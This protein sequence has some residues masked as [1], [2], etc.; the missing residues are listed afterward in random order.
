M[1]L[2]DGILGGV[3]ATALEVVFV[4]GPLF[5]F[6]A[7]LHLLERFTSRRLSERFGWWSLL[8][9]GWIGTPI[10]EL[11]H[12]AACLLFRHEI[13]EIALFRPDKRTGCL[14]FVNHTYNR[15]NPWH[16]AGN[17]FIGAAPLFGGAAA[18]F[19]AL[20]IFFPAAGRDITRSC[21]PD[22]LVSGNFFSMMGGYVEFSAGVFRILLRE[23]SPSSPW[24]YVFLYLVLSIGSHLAPSVKDME[25]MGTGLAVFLGILLLVNV[26]AA[27]LGGAPSGAVLAAARFLS[28]VVALF[29]A[30]TVLNAATALIVLCATLLAP[31]PGPR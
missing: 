6:A 2:L 26:A 20:Y 14:G 25:G 27:L 3:K 18:M 16:V 11:S 13:K 31:A 12:A 4:M 5:L 1:S 8:W 17:F 28:P 15:R 21:V 24:L 19:I 29:A 7:A 9:T 30:A 23:A 22:N 10:H